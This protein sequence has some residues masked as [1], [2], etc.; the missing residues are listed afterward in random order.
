MT[1]DH[2]SRRI[3]NPFKQ[4]QTGA[5]QKRRILAKMICLSLS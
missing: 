2:W 5:T 4:R 1:D 3:Y